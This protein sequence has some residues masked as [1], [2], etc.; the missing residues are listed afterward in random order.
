VLAETV[1][2]AAAVDLGR[3]VVVADDGLNRRGLEV[4]R[5]NRT[6]IVVRLL[7]RGG[8]RRRDL[9]ISAERAAIGI[10]CSDVPPVADLDL[11][12][13]RAREARALA[14]VDR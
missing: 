2:S 7:A 8:S 10:Q 5:L 4:E 9:R 6:V 13:R 1:N 3:P 11:A 14:V 12:V